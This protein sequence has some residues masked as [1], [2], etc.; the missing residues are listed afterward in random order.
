MARIIGGVDPA[1]DH[2][3]SSVWNLNSDIV[4][5]SFNDDTWPEV[6]DNSVTIKAWGAGGAGGY[7]NGG[8]AGNGGAG[9]FA[10]GTIELTPGTSIYI[11][12]GAGGTV[13]GN[14]L[15]PS[16]GGNGGYGSGTS[17]HKGGSGGG[18]AGVFLGSTA[19]DVTQTNA[20]LIAGGGG[21]GGSYD[22]DGEDE[23]G[24]GGGGSSGAAG[25]NSPNAGGGGT[26]SAG[27][28]AGSGATAGGALQGGASQGNFGMYA[29]GGGGGYWG[30]GGGS[31]S[32]TNGAEET[33]GGGGGSGFVKGTMTSTV[34]LA[35]N[36]GTAG[37]ATGYQATVNASADDLGSLDNGKGGGF[38][39]PGYKGYVS[40]TDGVGTRTFDSSQTVTIR[41]PNAVTVTA[42]V[43]GASGGGGN[44]GSAGNGGDGGIVKASKVLNIGDVLKIVVGNGGRGWYKT[45]TG[46]LEGNTS[47]PM[48]GGY[49]YCDVD[50]QTGGQGGSGSGV[51]VTSVT[52]SNAQVVAGGGGGGCGNNNADGGDSHTGAQSSDSLNG[53]DGGGNAIYKGIGATTSAGGTNSGIG[54][55]AGAALIGG[56]G[57]SVASTNGGDYSSAGS[58]GGGYYGGGGANHG[59]D[60]SS[61]AGGGAGSGYVESAWTRLTATGMSPKAGGAS[62]DTN[63]SYPNGANGEVKI[64]DGAGTTTYSTPGTFDHTVS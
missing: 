48:R 3:F 5:Q 55:G 12:V 59:G 17:S 53:S 1:T 44:S 47:D 31:V 60:A 21:G 7:W 19:S 6:V 13:E 22:R 32:G 36:N 27:G 2:N 46:A 51:F 37:S 52:H 57:G 63:S 40:I 11:V 42:E 25:L 14:T 35:G 4:S 64:T 58:G 23:S 29:G 39:S 41:D 9:G 28:T 38:N 26:Q 61:Q 30:G 18:F 43:F 49:L 16:V 33:G 50:N 56:Y 8:T 62:A 10:K 20:L 15:T 24:G 45:D 54:G 34:N